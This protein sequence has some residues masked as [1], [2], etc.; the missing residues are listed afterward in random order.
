MPDHWARFISGDWGSARPFSF[1]WWAVVSDDFKT[2]EGLTL[3]RGA[4]VRYREWYGMARDSHG[5]PKY[6][7][8]LKLEAEAVGRELKRLSGNEHIGVGVLDPA[9]FSSD[10]GPSIAERIDKGAG[11]S[12]FRRAD[13]CRVGTRGAMGGW[14]QMRSRLVGEADDRPMIAAFD[15][16]A[17]SIRTIPALQ[18]DRSR[19]EDVDTEGEDHA[20]DDWRYACMSRP[21]IR[22][23][24]N[25]PVAKYPIDRTI[26]EMIKKARDK[27]LANE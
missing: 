18:H 16:C 2:P 15:T 7:T 17:D 10:G 4:M 1:G 22:A 24:P 11:K 13:N 20:G 23:A 25:T 9:A 27:R 19:V 26:S 8:G 12:Y 14:D 3:P 5:Q 6:N 21:W